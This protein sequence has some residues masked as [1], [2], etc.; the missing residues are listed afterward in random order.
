MEPLVGGGPVARLA[1]RDDAKGIVDKLQGASRGLLAVALLQ[2]GRQVE[3]GIQPSGAAHQK[4]TQVR[5]ESRY[6]MQ[7]V[8]AL[9][10]YLVENQQRGPVVFREERI[11]EPETVLVVQH[12]QVAHHVRVTD[13]RAAESHGLVEDG[14]RVAH[15]TV[16]FV[17]NHVQ[18]LVVDC[19]PLLLGD[20]AQV[21]HDVGHADA[22]EVI[23]LAAA[24][25][26]RDDLVLLRR[27]EDEDCVCGRLLERLQERVESR[28]GEHM[29]L[30]DDI[31]AVASHL[32]RYLHLLH[33]SL[34]IL[35]AV[36][37]RGI[38][39]VDAVRASLAERHAGLTFAARFHIRRRV[40]TVDRLCENARGTGFAYTS[41]AAEQIC[42][43]QLAAENGILE[44]T[45]NIVLSYKTLEGIGAVLAG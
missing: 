3:K 1:L 39:L 15:S 4:V 10:Q 41:G 45:G 31:H 27:G 28:L 36:V 8:E 16:G 23:G 43:R 2:G 17:G 42:V 21:A 32:G 6:E 20:G 40:G 19:N 7:G 11:H 18:R 22:V 38:Q 33:Q 35:D 14:Q 13:V 30:V 26:G 9:G 12:V 29:H 44:G 34:D 5:A 37:G 25:D 24:Q